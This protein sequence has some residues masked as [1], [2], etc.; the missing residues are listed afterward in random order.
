MHEKII[1]AEGT[2]NIALIKYWG[3]RDSGLILPMNSSISLTLGKESK[4]IAGKKFELGT[5]TS[6]VFSKYIKEDAI[7]VNGKRLD[8]TDADTI[9]RFRAIDMMRE[10]AGTRERALVV[11]ENS[12]PTASGL[13]S[14]ASGMAALVYAVAYALELGLTRS[15]MSRY[16]RIGSGSA[17]RSQYLL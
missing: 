6:V 16:A 7:Y 13:A 12:F 1:T 4:M 9:E 5:K 17:C 10:R 14:S 11:S 15:D 3:K 8:L 2:P